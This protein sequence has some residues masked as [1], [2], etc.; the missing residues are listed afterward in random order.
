MK[1]IMGSPAWIIRLRLFGMPTSWLT[2][3]AMSSMRACRPSVM[4]DRYLARSSTEV[5]DQV[6][7][8]ALAA[9]T[10][11]STSS[12]VPSGTVAMTSSVVEFVTSRVPDPVEGTQAPSM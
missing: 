10:A 4:R 2:V 9:L 3:V 5:C 8:A 6:A 1:L 11:L 12:G 7:K